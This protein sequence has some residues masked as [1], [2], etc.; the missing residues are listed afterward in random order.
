MIKREKLE[1][2]LKYNE[3]HTDATTVEFFAITY[4][5]L[6]RYKRLSRALAPKAPKIL[7][8]DTENSP[9]EAYIWNT[10]VF[11][12]NVNPT[13][14]KNEWF[15]LTWSAKW[16]LDSEIM[17]DMLS[18]K[19]ALA[20]NDSRLITGLWKLFDEADIVIAHNAHE[21]DVSMANTKFLLQGHTPPS[22]YRIIDTLQVARRNFSFTYNK[23]SY[24][25]KMLGLEGKIDTDF[26][27]WIDCMKGK[28]K[29]LK[30]MLEYND[31]D[32]LLLEEVYIKLRPWIRSHPNLNIIGGTEMKCPSCGSEDI[33][34]RGQ[35]TTNAY[36]YDS[37]LCLDCGAYSRKTR[38]NLVSLAR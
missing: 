13:Q 20:G 9:L 30:E 21:F 7:V 31:R 12:V 27:L 17:H 33:K 29:A 38:T 8:F 32:V 36:S 28:K 5:T 11:N 24:L 2:I 22:P 18:S 6:A 10:R 14:I 1:E 4:E 25:A 19:E 37:Y 35:Y 23:L 3:S 26:E 34:P 15:M 16:L